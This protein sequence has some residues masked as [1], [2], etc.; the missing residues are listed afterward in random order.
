MATGLRGATRPQ[1]PAPPDCPALTHLHHT[2][3]ERHAIGSQEWFD[4]VGVAVRQVAQ[5]VA[6][7]VDEDEAIGV[8][9]LPACTWCSERGAWRS[10]RGAQARWA[11]AADACFAPVSAQTRRSSRGSSRAAS[12]PAQS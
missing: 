6:C 5:H 8:H 12:L 10:E 9:R 7:A 11:R 4:G 3:D 2:R 1:P